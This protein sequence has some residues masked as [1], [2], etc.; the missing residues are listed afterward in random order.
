MLSVVA[1]LVAFSLFVLTHWAVCILFRWRPLSKVLNLLWLC[2]IPVY[3]GIFFLLNQMF[4]EFSADLGT[5]DW[6]VQFGNGILIEGLL[7]IGY[8]PTFFVVERG[9]SLR[10]MIEISR[11]PGGKMSIEDI[12]RAYTYDYIL[13]K[14]LG[15]MLKMEYAVMDGENFRNTW[16]AERLVRAVRFVR[17]VFNVE[18]VMP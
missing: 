12:K 18:Q 3:A 16:R 13:E 10:I 11:A 1:V 5:F 15:Q 17:W 6:Y 14:R 4:P 2:F 9:I 7:L 8:T